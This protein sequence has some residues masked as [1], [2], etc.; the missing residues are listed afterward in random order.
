MSRPVEPRKP[1]EPTEEQI[2]KRA[3]AAARAQMRG[4][5]RAL[6]TRPG[7]A[8]LKAEMVQQLM[9]VIEQASETDVTAMAVAI[10]KA[11]DR[12]AMIRQYES[13]ESPGLDTVTTTGPQSTARRT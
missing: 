5:I 10:G 7:W 11:K 8:F 13:H 3:L 1:P 4:A 2:Q 12:V 6:A 9:V